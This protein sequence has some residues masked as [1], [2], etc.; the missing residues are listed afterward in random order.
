[1][2]CSKVMDR[3]TVIDA[4]KPAARVD[5]IVR[6]GR[7]LTVDLHALTASKGYS[8]PV[9]RQIA[10]GPLADNEGD[11]GSSDPG[12]N[13]TTCTVLQ[14]VAIRFGAKAAPV[15]SHAVCPCDE[16]SEQHL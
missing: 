5:G 13:L 4:M 10:V 16:F 12:L 7:S 8:A 3:M 1:M 6:P 15:Q 14:N 2:G 9:D 11:N